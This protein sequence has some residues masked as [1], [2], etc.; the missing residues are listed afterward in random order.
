MQPKIDSNF[1]FQKVVE[2]EEDEAEGLDDTPVIAESIDDFFE[3]WTAF[4]TESLQTIPSHIL[5]EFHQ[6]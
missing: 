3:V 6:I 4:L 2:D 5:Y 1:G